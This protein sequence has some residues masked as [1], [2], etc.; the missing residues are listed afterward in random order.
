MLRLPSAER[1]PIKPDRQ[2]ATSPQAGFILRSIA[3]TIADFG[4]VMATRRVVVERHLITIGQRRTCTNVH[5][6]R[7]GDAHT[8]KTPHRET[9][10]AVSRSPSRTMKRPEKSLGPSP[11]AAGGETRSWTRNVHSVGSNNTMA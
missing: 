1:F 9:T 4:S 5:R 10:I 2:V 8:I 3:D 6:R 11:K 7:W